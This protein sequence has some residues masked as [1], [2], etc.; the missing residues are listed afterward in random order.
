MSDK[1]AVPGWITKHLD[2]YAAAPEKG[3]LWDAS[4]AGGRPNT[5]TLLLTT[6]GRKSGK[7]ITMPLIYGAEGDRFI[8]VASKGGAPEHPAWFLNL[9]AQPQV[10]LQVVDKKFRAVA[11]VA[12]G[13]E[14]ARLWQFM[15]DIYSPY[16]DY[17]KKTTR[18]IPVVILTPVPA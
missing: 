6:T 7:Q 9:L 1:N 15:A 18:E 10:E 12:S 5:P 8:I 13:A 17:Q 2:E 16:I 4:F 3:H 11:S 14:R